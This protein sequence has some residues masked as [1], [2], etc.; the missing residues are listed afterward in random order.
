MQRP[1][2]YRSFT[3]QRIDHNPGNVDRDPTFPQLIEHAFRVSQE[4]RKIAVYINV[5]RPTRMNDAD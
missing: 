2:K 3:V 5:A 4:S 1:N